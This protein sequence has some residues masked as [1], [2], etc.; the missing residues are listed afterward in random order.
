V[1][2]VIVTGV[3][4]VAVKTNGHSSRP[5]AV[6]DWR[7]PLPPDQIWRILS[8]LGDWG[9]VRVAVGDPGGTVRLPVPLTGDASPTLGGNLRRIVVPVAVRG[10]VVAQLEVHLPLATDPAAERA[11]LV[12]A[13]HLAEAWSASRD[14]ESLA[15]EV[16][17][18]YEGL[19]LLYGLGEA[20]T[21]SLSV[22]T[23]TDLIHLILDQ[24]LA[25]LPAAWAELTLVDDL[26]T[27]RRPGLAV[28]SAPE[29]VA[30]SEHRLRAPLRSGGQEIG[31]LVLV[32]APADPP[33]SSDE[34]MLLDAVSTLVAGAARSAQLYEKLRRQT[35]ALAARET[36]LRA[37]LENV[38][39]GILTLDADGT[40]ESC[41]AAAEQ[42]FGYPAAEVV[43][44]AVTVLLPELADQDGAAR[45]RQLA[46]RDPTDLPGPP[47]RYEGPGRR[48]NGVSFPVDLAAS[49]IALGGR[50]L[51]IVSV[52]DVTERKRLE[53]L[54][55]HQALHDALT[56][57]PN[58]LLL[59][60]RLDHALLAGQRRHEPVALLMLDL[61]H[62][63]EVND[64]FGHHCGDRLLQQVA[65]RFQ[66]VVRGADTVARLGGDE[67]AVL[68]PATDGADAVQ[69]ARR[70]AYC[71]TPPFVVDGH[72]VG[73]ETSVGIALFPDHGSDTGALLR[74][75]DVAMYA[76]KRTHA[77]IC[78]YQAAEDDHSPDRLAMLGELRQA[79]EQDQLVLHYQPQLDFKT[80]RMT[81]VEALVRWQHPRNGLIA[82]A[83]FVPLAEQ[84]GLIEPLSQWVLN[85]ALQQCRRWLDDGYELAVSV[86]LAAPNLHDPE[87]PA[88]VAELLRSWR[89]PASCLKIEITE[90]S[91]LVEP[92]RVIAVLRQL[93]EIGVPI[94][95]D[96]FGTGFSSLAYLKRLPVDEIKIDRC[97]VMQMAQDGNDSAI[98]RSTIGLGHDLGM[99]VVAEGVETETTWNLLNELGCDLAQGFYLSPPV[100]A[101]ELTRYL[102]PRTEKSPRDSS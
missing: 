54:L 78:F 57:L 23:G 89:V 71:L 66:E 15:G 62:F 25:T 63:K 99:T 7:C 102:A 59:H 84:T 10:D 51:Y 21:T 82:P 19:H 39:E 13:R 40:I 5:L 9:A 73:L 61:D 93:R 64:T 58:R 31:H 87:L 2:G 45:L 75:A 36:Q 92:T 29:A 96:D 14:I 38:A 20:L 88:R 11:V 27:Y 77:G 30:E 32:R 42:I 81:R 94:G 53:G 18:A 34:G 56:N 69:V 47:P 80:G 60:E 35:D 101:A 95:I 91:L 79:I 8:I 22:A 48:K 3:V 43:G 68:L 17:H 67:F 70:L 1:D 33:F 41:N 16:I 76:A 97:F 4:P 74:Q 86:N 55:R 85:A 46:A 52:R 65:V 44:Q 6:P 12:T 83:Q 100:P 50:R 37:V 98:V 24:I 72:T 90:S 28:A 49:E 26:A